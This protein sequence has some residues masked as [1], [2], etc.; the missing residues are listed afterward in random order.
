MWLVVEF[1]YARQSTIRQNYV[2]RLT[3]GKLF[4]PLTA[5]NGTERKTFMTFGQN[6]NDLQSLTIRTQTGFPHVRVAVW[7]KIG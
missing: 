2:T 1:V 7:M 4:S 5:A 6:T 3:F